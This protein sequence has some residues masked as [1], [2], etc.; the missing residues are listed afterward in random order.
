MTLAPITGS[1]SSA[2]TTVPETFVWA[3]AVPIM[4]N[5]QANKVISLFSIKT[6]SLV[7]IN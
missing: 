6:L 5:R 3:N 2:D 7:V 4:R 1:P